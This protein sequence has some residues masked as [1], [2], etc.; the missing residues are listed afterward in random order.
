MMNVRP[1][2]RTTVDPAWRFSDFSEFLTFIGS[3]SPTPC[4]ERLS[5]ASYS[6]PTP[7][8]RAPVNR[9]WQDEADTGSLLEVGDH[10][11]G[12]AVPC[13]PGAVIGEAPRQ[14]SSGS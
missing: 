13:R 3:S 8:L 5:S 10:L 11:I 12:D 9:R 4:Q 1:R 7:R 14:P 6:A 2:R